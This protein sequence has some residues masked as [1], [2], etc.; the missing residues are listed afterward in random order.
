MNRI[1]RKIVAVV[2]AAATGLSSVAAG[3]QTITYFHNDVAGSPVAATNSAGDLVWK[4]GYTP[5]GMKTIQSAAAESNRI[6]YTGKPYDADLDLSYMGARYYSPTYGRFLGMDPV[7]FDPNNIH[8]FN[9]YAYA[10]N[11]PYRYVDKDGRIPS[12]AVGTLIIATGLLVAA[13]YNTNPAAQQS[14]D[15]AVRAASAAVQKLG[16]WLRADAAEGADSPSNPP[17]PSSG[18]DPDRGDLTKAG[19]A[20]QKHGDR[21]G[22][23]FDP[24]RGT[25]Q[26]K[27]AQGQRTLDSIV[28][29]PDRVDRPNRHGGTDVL[30]RPG[31]RGARFGRDGKFT[32]FLEP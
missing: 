24:A 3:A 9:R 4:E 21:A 13:N 5:Y 26:D 15:Q 16:N 32:G 7:E 6:G 29:S 30:E 20:Q 17:D 12:L 19:R 2:T 31:G 27:N 14:A 18:S 11:N 8:S 22:S 28:N 23:A 1:F 25:P 10:N